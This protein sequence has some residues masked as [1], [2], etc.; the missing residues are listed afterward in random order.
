MGNPQDLSRF[1]TEYSRNLDALL[2]PV[3][4]PE[5]G[6]VLDLFAGCGG[7]ALGLESVGFETYGIEMNP[8]AAQTYNINLAGSCSEATLTPDFEF[9]DA[10]IVV[11]GPPCQ[12]FSV[13]GLQLG[14][15]DARDGFPIFIEAVRELRPRLWLFEN[16]RGMLYR[17]RSYLHEVLESLADLGYSVSV[18]LLN[19]SDYG[20]PQNRERLIAV[21]HDGSFQ[22]PSPLPGPKTTAGE[23]LGPLASY[24]D[25]TSL[26]LT[27][28]QATYIARYE[29]KSKCA[30]PRDLH[31][32][33]VARTLTCR[34][35]AGS[36]SDMHRV[37]LPD[38]RRRRLTV[39]EAARLQSFPDWFQF[40]GSTGVQYEQI[41]NAVAPLFGRTLGLSI[42]QCITGEGD[43][44]TA[45]ESW[46]LDLDLDTRIKWAI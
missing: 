12:P 8:H 33:R 41:G 27:E 28:A 29:E 17:N 22:F 6:R 4:D 36:T 21:G 7:L 38:G 35:L 11:G 42:R 32:D 30:V 9:P 19:A 40:A 15:A 45:E 13:G 24:S 37:L 31:L 20:V 16:V 25:E 43:P 14:L 10:D 23:A 18:A 1:A 44:A 26:F 3:A 39:R 5:L 34:N 2:K 46:T